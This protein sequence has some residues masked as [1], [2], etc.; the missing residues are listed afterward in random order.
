MG[1][2]HVERRMSRR[3][4]TSVGVQVYAY[5]VL[6]AHGATVDM[7]EGGVRISIRQ[8]LSGGELEVGKYL[9]VMFEH[10]TDPQIGEAPVW[11]PVRVVRRMPDY[12][13]AAF[14][15]AG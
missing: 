7:S 10:G 14:L 8:D 5:G 13:A 2:T 3:S 15:G 6:V 12:L 9:D 1:A 11:Q 4:D